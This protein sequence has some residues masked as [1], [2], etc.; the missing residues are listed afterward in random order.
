M[1]VS[2]AA[3]HSSPLPAAK[4]TV[5]AEGM[6]S[7]PAVNSL[8]Q[9]LAT[10]AIVGAV[11]APLVEIAQLDAELAIADLA[12]A[13]EL[14]YV[15]SVRAPAA[16]LVVTPLVEPEMVADASPLGAA[17]VAYLGAPAA[18]LVE[19]PL[20]DAPLS[21]EAPL[22]AEPLAVAQAARAASQLVAAASSLKEAPA[23]LEVAAGVPPSAGAAGVISLSVEA[24][25]V[26][27]PMEAVGSDVAV[28]VL[29]E[30][31]VVA[32]LL[33][34]VGASQNHF[35]K[36]PRCPLTPSWLPLLRSPWPTCCR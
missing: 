28:I 21:V 33:S 4:A 13:A 19:A 15:A 18:L 1:Q 11:V 25:G 7:V 9:L 2:L 36:V 3:P 6:A 26:P 16:L 17:G 35:W 27:P 5:E 34:L 31:A 20:A 30:A 32:A 10:V 8:A 14:T 12:V 24:L 22:V 23:A 29:A